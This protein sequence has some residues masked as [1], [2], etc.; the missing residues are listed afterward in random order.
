MSK[1][2]NP[3][4][5]SALFDQPDIVELVEALIGIPQGPMR[6]SLVGLLRTTA[7][8][9]GAQLTAEPEAPPPAI[10]GVIPRALSGPRLGEV[11]TDD[12]KVRAVEMLLQRIPP[13]VVAAELDM[14][15]SV[16]MAARKHAQRNGVTFPN[17]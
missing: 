5:L 8:T 10:V 3:S 9:Y 16:V 4:L 12:P 13:H 2:L 14:H 1:T 17:A 6:S 7:M 11:Q 15:I